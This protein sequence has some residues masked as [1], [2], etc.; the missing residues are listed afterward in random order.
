MRGRVEVR[1]VGTVRGSGWVDLISQESAHSLW[2]LLRNSQFK[3][4]VVFPDIGNTSC[5]GFWP[6]NSSFVTASIAD[7]T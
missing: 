6:Q 3:S 2:R 4:Y 5:C 1:K 7:G